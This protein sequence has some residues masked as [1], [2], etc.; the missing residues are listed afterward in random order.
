MTITPTTLTRAAAVA[1]VVAGLIFIGVQINHPHT[2][3]ASI[4]TTEMAV[5]GTLKVL[6]TMLALVG[7]TGMY[8]RQVKQ[9]GVL[10]L[11]GYL[12]FSIGYLLIMSTTLVSAYVLPSLTA[13]DPGYVNDVVTAATGGAPSGDIGLLQ[14]VFQVQGIAY[15]AG[16][17]VFGIALFRARVLA[18]WAAVLL[19]V[20]GV[21]SAAL[22][23]MP[24]AFY[25]FLAF[26]NGIAMVALGYSLWRTARTDTAT[27]AT[28]VDG[29][30]VATTA[31]AE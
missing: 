16:G 3:L 20:G 18:R 28:P 4:T 14:S 26:P 30:R 11:L 24:D 22:S 31:G 27:L 21:V 15:L 12:V 13:T 2:D 29:P 5:R 6:M 19:A 7:I 17:L 9:S 1:A 8:L 23:V 25:R 10:G